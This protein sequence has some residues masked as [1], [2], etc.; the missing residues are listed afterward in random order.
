MGKRYVV[1]LT[2]PERAQVVQVVNDVNVPPRVRLWAAILLDAD[3]EQ[4]DQA[5]AT[6]CGTSVA[7][8]QRTRRRFA[9]EGLASLLGRVTHESPKAPIVLGS[10]RWVN[11]VLGR[12]R[13]VGGARQAALLDWEQ[14]AC[15]G[16]VGSRDND[17]CV[18]A[19]TVLRA[20]L[21]WLPANERLEHVAITAPTHYEL[22]HVLVADAPM[23]LNVQVNRHAVN[24][25]LAQHQLEMIASSIV[26]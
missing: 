3:A 20:M 8:V 24:L 1:R 9:L 16:F 26:A 19:H 7:T 10:K 15:L 12:A 18:D 13:R 4:C 17:W 2:S 22:F 21:Q 11:E 23:V 25:A 5:I 6:H 14:Q